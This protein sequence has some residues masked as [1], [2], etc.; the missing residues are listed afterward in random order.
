VLLSKGN[1]VVKANDLQVGMRA[2]EGFNVLQLSLVLGAVDDDRDVLGILEGVHE[3]GKQVRVGEHDLGLGLQHGVL[4]TFLAERVICGDDAHGLRE[5]TYACQ[6]ARPMDHNRQSLTMGGA[7]PLHAGRAEQVDAVVG[8]ETHVLHG[9]ADVDA[10]LLELDEAPPLVRAELE[11]L[12]L[13]VHLL[14]LAVD[15]LLDLLGLLVDRD[16]LAGADSFRVAELGR[17]IA[18]HIVERLDVVVGRQAQRVGRLCIS[19]RDRLAVDFREAGHLG[20][21]GVVDLGPRLGHELLEIAWHGGGGVCEGG[22]GEVEG[23]WD[24]GE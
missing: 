12:P 13:L 15:H 17:R 6:R 2:G 21:E 3:L 24:G 11:V 19:A 1:K 10:Q 18:Q 5:G 14:L 7:Q 20:G 9:G 23:G 8:N 4:E 16:D 22:A